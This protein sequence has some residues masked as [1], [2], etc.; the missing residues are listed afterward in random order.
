MET[1]RINKATLMFFKREPSEL[2]D[3]YV[4][5]LTNLSA[6]DIKILEKKG[7]TI[8]D[9][10]DNEKRKGWGKY[11]VA[12]SQYA[13]KV[14]DKNKKEIPESVMVGNGTIANA[15]VHVYDW[16]FKGKKGKSLGCNAV[17]ILDLVPYDPASLDQFEVEEEGYSV[18]EDDVFEDQ[19]EVEKQTLKKTKKGKKIEGSEEP[20]FDDEIPF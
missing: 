15:A 7:I 13:P 14:V 9:E 6:S 20:D 5:N 10:K 1:F 11:V 12:K 3:K 16:V 19:D 2:E 18:E 8:R 17:Q 4:V